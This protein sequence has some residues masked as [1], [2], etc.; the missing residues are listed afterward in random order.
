[1]GFCR[2]GYDGKLYL[3]LCLNCKGH[4][5]TEMWDHGGYVHCVCNVHIQTVLNG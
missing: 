5:I 3:G 2:M 1:M 4:W